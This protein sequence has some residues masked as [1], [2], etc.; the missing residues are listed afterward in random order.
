MGLTRKLAAYL[1]ASSLWIF[2]DLCGAPSSPGV[3][4]K[5]VPMLSKPAL[6][7]AVGLAVVPQMVHAGESAA[8]C[9][10]DLGA[11]AAEARHGK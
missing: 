8:R 9:V 5:E 3:R 2:A 7:L 10:D 1:A 11:H 4:M 6:G